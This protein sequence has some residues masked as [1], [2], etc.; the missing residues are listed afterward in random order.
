VSGNYRLKNNWSV[1]GQYAEGSIVPPSSVFD[2]NQ[3]TT[4]RAIGVATLP[5]QQK[6]TTYQTG[7]VLKLKNVTFDADYFHIHF[8]NGYSSVTTQASGG[9]PVFFA[10]PPSVTQGIEGEANVYLTHGLGA[11]LNASYDKA[12]YSGGSATATCAGSTA[13]CA[14]AGVLSVNTP[15]GLNV[16][17]TPSDLETEGVTYQR[18]SW[19][20]ALFN[21]RV[22]TFYIDSPN[23]YHNAYTVN[24]FSVTN[25]FINYT[26]R[27]GGR[28]NNTKLRLSFN[29]LF[30]NSNINGI[31]QANNSTGQT[32]AA[33]GTT[34]TNPFL[35][36]G[37]PAISG[38][39]NVSVNAGRS[40]MLTV[41]FGTSTKR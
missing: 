28:F 35:A 9:E 31:T 16:Q 8:A 38:A 29:N 6:N 12:V 41:T 14:A 11:Y 32:I 39:D 37:P 17:Q 22:G 25:A 3:G 27:S 33:N 2:F 40:I 15:N 30:G 24:P 26:I 18:N 34:Y 7:T 10:T 13:A 1:Y 20:A 36:T 5:Q 4:G 23:G 21:K 19:D